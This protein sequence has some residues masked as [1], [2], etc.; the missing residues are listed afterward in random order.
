MPWLTT[1]GGSHEIVDGETIVGSGSHAGW[2]LEGRDLA[3][4]HFVVER[5][6]SRVRVRPCGI[7]AV[8]VVNGAQS[9]ANPVELR[10]GDTIDAGSA[11]FL[12]SAEQSGA[13]PAAS[14]VE[15]HLLETRS[16][17]VHP[18]AAP[19][20]GV[21]RDRQNAVVVRDPTASRFHAEIRR[22][23]GGFVLHPHG[24]AGTLV[25]SRRIG[26]PERLRDGDRIEIANV[27]LRFV[28]GPVPPGSTFAETIV[29]EEASQRPT[30]PE[31]AV[32]EIPAEPNG[33]ARSSRLIWIAALLVAAATVW[34]ATR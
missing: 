18:L 27:E 30:V 15:A 6:G 5:H 23:A 25:N 3:P 7:D 17:I 26:T 20:T 14:R 22:E 29:D 12:Y 13:F 4:R 16:G 10:N 2:R 28:M 21:G 19:S 34:L 1:E 8:L 31:A 9:G 11:R 33:Q 32:T 24:S